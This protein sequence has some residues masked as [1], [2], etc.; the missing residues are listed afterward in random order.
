MP[1]FHIEKAFANYTP[2]KNDIF[3]CSYF[4]SG[5]NW[6]MQIA[7]QIANRGQGEYQ[8]I[9]DVIAWPDVPMKNFAIPILDKSPS[10]QSITGLRAIKTHLD[11]NFVPYN[12]QAKYICVVRDPKDVFVSS[13]FFMRSVLFGKLMPSVATW[14][15]LFLSKFAL[16]GPWA[17]FLH[18]YWSWRDRS[19]VLFLTFEEMKEDLPEV[20]RKTTNLLGVE[21][22]TEEFER[23][24][25]LS[26][27]SYMKMI[28]LRNC[29]IVLRRILES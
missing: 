18:S 3:V 11:G 17:N 23:V 1:F 24:C 29:K 22:S 6:T 7:H 13:Y 8:N 9:H 15:D 14:L 4:K 10:Q 26:S 28:E 16:H 25:Y 12:K 5:T 19:N 2:I 27:Y 21:L 20:I